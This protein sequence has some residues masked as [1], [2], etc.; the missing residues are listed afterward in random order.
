MCHFVFFIS[1]MV[2]IVK[3]FR[4][5]KY[6]GLCT[7]CSKQLVQQ[8]PLL[9][10]L[11]CF[12]HE[13]HK[14]KHNRKVMPV[15]P[16]IHLPV[17]FIS[18]TMDLAEVLHRI[19]ILKAVVQSSFSSVLIQENYYFT[20]NWNSISSIFSKTLVLDCYSNFMIAIILSSISNWYVLPNG[21]WIMYLLQISSIFIVWEQGTLTT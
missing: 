17:H 16:P 3:N 2:C 6:T 18:E 4:R 9:W 20:W 19:Y 12:S 5:C 15:S 21:Q 8:I 10:K 1:F 11:L 7:G 13:V 14:I